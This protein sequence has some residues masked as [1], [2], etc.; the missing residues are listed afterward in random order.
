MA[1]KCPPPKLIDDA[2][3]YAEYKK[4]LQ[5]WSRITKVEQ[6]KQA[7]VVLYALKDHHS[8]IQEKIDTTLGD[9]IVDKDDG[10]EK[11]IEYLDSI[12]EMDEMTNMWS[13]YKKFVRL[14]KADD[15]PIK[16]FNAEFET[17][18]KEAKDNGCEVSDTVLALNLLESCNLS[19]TEEKFV[20][21]G[22]DFKAGREKKDCLDQ[23]KKSLRKFQ[24]REEV[25]SR[26]MK[27]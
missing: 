14:K 12:Y 23:V 27:R 24:S 5:R 17:A 19:D 1:S 15:Q 10:L 18:Y 9:Q 25:T 8:G 7:E 16:E 22:I 20:L 4:Q 3:G 11:L 6:K 2:A 21:T 26:K 13:K